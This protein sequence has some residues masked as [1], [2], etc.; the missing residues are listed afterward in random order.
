LAGGGA[1]DS[2]EAQEHNSGEE[3][4]ELH[5]GVVWRGDGAFFPSDLHLYL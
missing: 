1:E 3:E 4:S 2:S 5:S